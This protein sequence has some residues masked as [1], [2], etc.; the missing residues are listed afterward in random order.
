MWEFESADG[1]RTEAS[2]TPCGTRTETSYET[3]CVLTSPSETPCGKR[4]VTPCELPCAPSSEHE[5]ETSHAG[6]RTDGGDQ[7][8]ADDD[9]VEA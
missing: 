4:S 3:L 9:H 2:E 6:R 7:K 1:T 8:N 5:S